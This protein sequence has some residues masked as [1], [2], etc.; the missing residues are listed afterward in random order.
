MAIDIPYN[1]WQPLSVC[2]VVQLFAHASFSWG[3]GGGYAVEQFLGTAIRAHDD[4]DIVVF[5]D[6][7]LRLQQWM[8]GWQLYAADPPGTLRPWLADEDLPVGI[9]DLWGHRRN[10]HAW[11]LQIMLA[12]VEGDEWFSRR[13]HRVRGQ[14][15]DL[16]VTYD[17]I[18]CVR[19]EVQLLDK[20]RNLRPK[21]ERDFRACLP[22][23]RTEAKRWLANQ[24]HQTHP[25]G[26][27]WLPS[28]A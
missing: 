17:G 22:L 8:T 6:E 18:P 1:T 5:R 25:E 21:D 2:D 19:I 4:I 13:N 27:P 15:N 3:L 12:E 23:L 11:Q 20:A 24:L 28:L 9:H 16:L 10:A 14:R 7:Q 26:H